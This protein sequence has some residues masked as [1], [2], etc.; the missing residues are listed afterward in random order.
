MR[1]GRSA[2]LA[3]VALSFTGPLLAARL[4]EP[5]LDRTS[6]SAAGRQRAQVT[7]SRFGRYAVVARSKEGVSVQVVDRMAGPVESAGRPEEDGRLDLFLERGEYRLLTEGHSR[8]T[9]EARLEVRGF[10]ELSAPQPP[11]LVET[12]LVE[13]SLDDFQQRS[14]WLLVKERRRVD[15]EAAGRNL[16][17]LRLWR[18]G[19]WLV[20]AAPETE[21]T[22]PKVGQPL[23]ACRLST[24]L[25][26]GLYLVTAYGGPP[27][28]WAQEA[29]V[30]PLFVRLGL[31]R[32][33]EAGRRRF[34]VSPFGID[35]YRVPGAATYFRLELPEARPATLRAATFDPDQPYAAP[36]E[37]REVSKKSLPPVAEIDLPP[38][39][40]AE[41]ARESAPD[42]IVTV[43]GEAGQEYVLQQFDRRS[44]YFF[45]ADGSYWLSSVHS[46]H[47]QDSVDVTALLL[48]GGSKAP[49]REEL[50]EIGTQTGWKRRAN[51]LAPLTVFLRVKDAGRYEVLLEG[52]EA[53]ARI[54][55]FLTYRPER[56]KSPPFRG[57]GSTWDLDVGFYVFT[58]EPVK[59]GIATFTVRATGIVDQALSAVGMARATPEAAVRAAA[60][61]PK[62]ELDR[63]VAYAVYL[64]EQ[65][66]V[67]SGVQLRKLPLD[68][69]EPLF[70][71]QRPG[72][73][74]T[75]S[76]TVNEPGLLRAE[77]ESGTP[78]DLSVDGAL[79]VRAAALSPGAHSVVVRHTGKDTVQYTLAFE[80]AHLA[81]TAALP[82]LSA[83]ATPVAFPALAEG[84]PVFLDLAA[85]ASTTF[86]VRADQ[87][88][89]YVLESTGLLATEGNVRSRV[90]TSFA[91]ASG[92][93]TGRNF[94]LREYLREGD[95]QLT[96]AAQAPSTG[97][98]GVQLRRTRVEDGGDLQL[99]LPARATL[100]GG[101][102]VSYRFTITTPGEFRV[103][104]LGLSRSFRCR[105]E[106]RDG[107]PLVPP[108][109]P[110]DVTRT[111]EPGRYRFV[112]LPEA[113]DA[114]AVTVIEPMG[115]RR[116]RE[117]HGPH[118]LPLGQTVE[119]VWMEPAEG[120]ERLPDVWRLNLPAATD[121]AW[122]L[123]AGMEGS[124]LR[125]G[126]GA[127][128]AMLGAGQPVKVSLEAGSY[129][130]E[131][132]SARRNN[133]LAYGLA[134]FPEALLPG[135]DREVRAPAEV[136]LAVGA[137]GLVEVSSLGS[138]DVKARLYD[139]AGAFLAASDDHPDDWNFQIGLN[140]RP[141]RYL[142]RVDPVGST[143]G[144]TTVRLRT[145]REEEKPALALPASVAARPGRGSL[146]F[147]L[148][149]VQGDLLLAQVRGAE[150]LGLAVEAR[151]IDAWVPL[152]TTTGRNPRLELPLGPAP[153]ALRLRLWSQDR[154]DAAVELKVAA[155]SAP[156]A[157]EADL[158]RG[159]RLPPVP[160]LP[161]T[162]AAV[163]E[164]EGPGLLR[165]ADDAD[166]RLGALPGVA[167]RAATN[168]LVAVAGRR[169]YV[170]GVSS[171][172]ATPAAR[173]ALRLIVRAERVRLVAGT[174]LVVPVPAHGISPV[175]AAPSAG[176]LVVR[177]RSRSLQP[178]LVLGEAD[179]AL[180]PTGAMAVAPGLAV[181]VALQ[182]KKP[183][184]LVFAATPPSPGQGPLGEATLEVV[185]LPRPAIE[186]LQ[187]GTKDGALDGLAAVTYS[188]P[189][190]AK[191]LRLGL[192][193]DV[194]AVLATAG[195]TLS[196]VATDEAAAAET[197]DT[198][199]E[200][201]TLL[202]TGAGSGR[203]SVEN[204]AA[205][206]RVLAESGP[207][208]IVLAEAGTLRLRVTGA[209]PKVLR[210][211]GVASEA[212][213]VAEDGSV[214]GGRDIVASGAGTLLVR[215]RPGPLV[216]W[217][218]RP[219]TDVQALWSVPGAPVREVALPSALALEGEALRLAF[220]RAEST[221]LQLRSP[222][223]LVTVLTRPNG[224]VETEVHTAATSLDALLPAGRSELLLR[225]SLGR[226][227]DGTAT[228]QATP[229]LPIA[230]GLGPEILLAP[231]SS[232]AFTFEVVDGG[233][234]G[235]GVRA[236]AEV[237]EATLFDSSGQ[238]L[239]TGVSQM[240]TL[241]PGRYVLVVHAPADGPAV[242]VRPALAG[243]LR[244]ST[245]P[246]LDVVRRYLELEAAPLTFSSRYVEEGPEARRGEETGAPEE[247]AE[248]LEGEIE[249]ETAEEEPPPTD[250][251]G[252][253]G[254]FWDVGVW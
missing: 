73:T 201:L 206:P 10:S 134:A 43:E 131:V 169:V 142:L 238:R 148:A 105:L 1:P 18:D 129:R 199:A 158:R 111:F 252:A 54:E 17:D 31:A 9:G 2:A 12:K 55:P 198:A 114:R 243:A 205:A 67:R 167:L 202:H 8:A 171:T 5:A 15:L 146:V 222:E 16:A 46:G 210:L 6:V 23:L 153:P 254:T 98:L 124:L 122:S 239:A 179:D 235:L 214:A 132:Q 89:L 76:I 59:R 249:E 170:V 200:T 75:V 93:G 178:G 99:R 30:H 140:L 226:R 41:P 53:R 56:Y 58:A 60:V 72:E 247:G 192:S 218:E 101:E 52:P 37:M 237:A 168:G 233:P 126:G 183:L 194:V 245:D 143:A 102:A 209:E 137:T 156:K 138:A 141:G 204:V 81:R 150:S 230:E 244:P 193:R 82:P 144:S 65:P 159:L 127:A 27:Q 241:A 14:F 147:P 77:A 248:V 70:V 36:S 175:E 35:R 63:D 229:T 95:Y 104:T 173:A 234:L 231:G 228:L 80:P 20:D 21:R 242:R 232:R 44:V 240:P 97:R 225:P 7:V 221:L 121:V 74:V 68:P 166:L 119:H 219:G 50:V 83:D 172:E 92:N 40:A 190:G 91:R 51:L 135:M 42:R 253:A 79:A 116:M 145:P 197:L 13:S 187:P 78:V 186:P 184:A 155:I 86:G 123:G 196:V 49:L 227:L 182:P 160:G 154:R 28:A 11:M 224:S 180:A 185:T 177:A 195:R 117:G 191:R 57:T 64:N 152:G 109:G 157:R 115:R 4:E 215:H 211:R 165:V 176:P 71:S 39:P 120:Q 149:A 84:T 203:F 22:Q 3:F 29:E 133:R 38:A 19:Q 125:E 250:W 161:A 130:F 34:T 66:E 118:P 188:L 246:P 103:R 223:P 181:A 213:F 106:D 100:H 251:G 32:L 107:W 189:A 217:L 26:P 164:I 47:P 88:G 85:G 33:P 162:A 45:R 212:T 216:A 207:L 62:I 24:E 90:V 94:E 112:V 163:I 96:V 61:F 174:P 87:A 110:A 236:S 69:T 208:E 48:A 108:G 151:E 220:D 113:T 136:P 128:V 25:E 139:S